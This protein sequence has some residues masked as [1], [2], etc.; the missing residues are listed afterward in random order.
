VKGFF[1]LLTLRG[2]VLHRRYHSI[3]VVAVPSKMGSTEGS[4]SLLTVVWR[5]GIT[6]DNLL[7]FLLCDDNVTVR[8]RGGVSVPNTITQQGTSLERRHMDTPGTLNGTGKFDD[9]TYRVMA[10]S[11]R[12]F[13]NK[14][15]LKF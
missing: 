12:A 7:G 4:K 14:L 13:G 1:S 11:K 5:A 2:T 3:R 15:F 8:L 10:S 6:G 9:E